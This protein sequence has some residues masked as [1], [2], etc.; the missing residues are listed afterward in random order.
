VEW[1]SGNAKSAG[2]NPDGDDSL[3]YDIRYI[4]DNGKYERYVEVKVIGRE[5]SF[6]ISASEVKFGEKMKK[7]YEIFLV[8]NINDPAH[9]SIEV[10]QGPFDYKGGSFNDN[11]FFTVINDSYILKFENE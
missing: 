2:V 8:R 7:N 10:I 1:V 3:G 9:M 6:H 4:P 11:E 5:N